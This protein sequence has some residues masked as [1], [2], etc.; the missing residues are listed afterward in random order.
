MQPTHSQRRAQQLVAFT[1]PRID[2]SERLA[3]R[4]PYKNPD[5]DHIRFRSRKIQL[6]QRLYARIE[7]CGWRISVVHP[8]TNCSSTSE[9][10]QSRAEGT[11]ANFLKA[12]GIF[13]QH[14]YTLVQEGAAGMFE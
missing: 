2:D 3:N 6:N 7:V 10:G 5:A 11:I 14:G 9:N 1:A 13:A 12:A 4:D 8:P